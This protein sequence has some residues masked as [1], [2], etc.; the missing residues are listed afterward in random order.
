[1]GLIPFEHIIG[2]AEVI[3]FSTTGSENIL[4]TGVRP[5]RIFQFLAP[6]IL[7]FSQPTSNIIEKHKD[8]EV[9]IKTA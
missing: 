3:F 6:S 2:R 1:M 9:I 7:H 5:E 4:P 8:N